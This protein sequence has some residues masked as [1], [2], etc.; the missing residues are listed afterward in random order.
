MPKFDQESAIAAISLQ[1]LINRWSNDL[2]QNGG[3]G[4][5]NLVTADCN[6]LL[7]GKSF[8]GPEA[9]DGFYAARN[10]RV[11]TQQKDGIRTQRHT[12][13]N[14]LYQFSFPDKAGVK[15]TLVNFSAEGKAP[16]SHTTPTII[17]DC[18]MDCERGE[19][20]EWR[21]YKFDSTPIFIGNDPF[22]NASVVPKS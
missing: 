17:A 1:Q 13:T 11:R 3:M 19:D 8:V 14:L 12:V 6:Y 5:K 10:E 22:L 16:V 20:G 21:I 4:V 15:F 2:D 18:R 7:G 9:I